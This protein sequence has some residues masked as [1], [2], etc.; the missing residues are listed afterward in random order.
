MSDTG[1][2]D[3]K[4]GEEVAFFGSYDR[5]PLIATIERLTPIGQIVLCGRSARYN[6]DGWQR[7]GSS[8]GTSHISKLNPQMRERAQRRMALEFLK[9]VPWSKLN[10]ETLLSIADLVR[11]EP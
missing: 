3:W 8:Y 6:N 11:K 1:T 10:T 7:G 9:G 4:A 2:F 5:E